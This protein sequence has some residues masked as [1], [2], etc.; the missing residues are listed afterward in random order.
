MT[1]R[2]DCHVHGSPWGHS[3]NLAMVWVD[4]DALED[5][6]ARLLADAIQTVR[7]SR[8]LP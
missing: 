1:L 4:D 7:D 6:S 5:V 8:I 3:E 2:R